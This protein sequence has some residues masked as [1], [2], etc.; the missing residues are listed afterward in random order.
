[1]SSA[2][3]RPFCVGLNV[4]IPFYDDT[5]IEDNIK[6][7]AL[8]IWVHPFIS[9]ASV[10]I[11]QFNYA[12]SESTRSWGLWV[13]LKDFLMSW[14]VAT[15]ISRIMEDFSNVMRLEI[16]RIKQ[17]YT[18][19]RDEIIQSFTELTKDLPDIHTKSLIDNDLVLWVSISD[20][21]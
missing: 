21:S 15:L 1:M 8:T 18:N 19:A 16:L 20:M 2:K 9:P 5:G 4:L 10:D 7:R 6:L 3:W 14:N 11:S 17:Q 12:A 13:S